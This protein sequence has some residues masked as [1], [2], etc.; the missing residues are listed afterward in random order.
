MKV[1]FDNHKSE[2]NKEKHGIDFSAAQALW[3]DPDRIEIP[4]RTEDEHGYRQDRGPR[5]VCRDHV[6]RRQR[7]D[8]FRA[9]GTSEGG[10]DL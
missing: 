4:A 9:A 10:R 3:E 1:E 5:V 6:S 2:A 8:H 7:S